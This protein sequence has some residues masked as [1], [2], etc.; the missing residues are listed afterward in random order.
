LSD[1]ALRAGARCDPSGCVVIAR[2]GRPVSYVTDLSALEEDC[3]RAAVVVTRLDAPA[4]KAP[5]VLDRPAL[6]R[7]GA[8]AARFEEAELAV[9]STRLKEERRPWRD[10]AS[11]PAPE[12]PTRDR[13]RPPRPSIDLPDGDEAVSTGEPD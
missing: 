7:R 8:T 12:A 5:L 3:G 11:Q 4:C 6:L 10:L 9:R 2:G 13:P 1:A